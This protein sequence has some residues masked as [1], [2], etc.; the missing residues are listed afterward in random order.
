[1]EELPQIKIL[2]SRMLLGYRCTCHRGI[3]YRTQMAFNLVMI[4]GTQV[5]LNS[6]GHSHTTYHGFVRCDGPLG[7]QHVG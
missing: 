3:L 5:N 7:P 4:G 2:M 1:M 6:A